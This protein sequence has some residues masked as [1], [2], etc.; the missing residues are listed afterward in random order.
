M[1]MVILQL[2]PNDGSWNSKV[3][4]KMQSKDVTV[5]MGFANDLIFGLYW[6]ISRLVHAPL[7][8]II[9]RMETFVPILKPIKT[10]YTS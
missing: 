5:F 10:V 7:L 1:W 3:F 9:I 8:N 4:R 2:Q 6:M